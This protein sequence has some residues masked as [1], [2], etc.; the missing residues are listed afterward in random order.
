MELETIME[1][2]IK[3]L[4]NDFY[5]KPFDFSYSSLNKLMWNPQAFYQMYVL[6]NREEKTESYLVNGKV[7]HCLL[8]EPEK[9]DQEFIISPSVLPTGNTKTVVDTVFRHAT[10]LQAQGDQ[11]KDFT[12]FADAVIDVL[13]DINL[14][15]ALKTDQQRIDKVFTPEAMNYWNFL[16]TKGDKILIDQET[17]DFCKTAVDIV[18]TDNN[19]C[20]LIGCNKN[21]FD[22][23]EVF[24]ELPL[25]STINNKT[26]GLKGIIDNLVIDHDKKILYI[27][28]I[29]TSS[30][31]LKDFSESIEFYNYWLQA[32]IYIALVSSNFIKLIDMGYELKFHFVVIDRNYQTYAFPLSN[33]TREAWFKKLTTVLEKAQWHYSNKSYTL[34]YEFALQTVTL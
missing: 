14:H 19:I 29:K 10:E 33:S 8:L 12:D 18:K 27:N 21:D 7:I 3:N 26:F 6:G 20:N 28:D 25:R 17:F 22:N 2:S 13:K 23:K 15:Q 1:E 32:S 31:D 16:M 34:P 4:E 5:S 11:R 24:N 30:K 9:F